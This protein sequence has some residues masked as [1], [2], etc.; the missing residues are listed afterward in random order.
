M[1]IPTALVL[2]AN[3]ISTRRDSFFSSKVALW[4][5]EQKAFL[6][7]FTK[8]LISLINQFPESYPFLHP[9]KLSG[10]ANSE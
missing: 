6:E 1:A 8:D 4:T 10:W 5:A 9:V 2:S 7:P 3:K